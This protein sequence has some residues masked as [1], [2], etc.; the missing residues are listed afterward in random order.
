MAGALNALTAKTTT[1]TETIINFGWAD[2][3]IVLLN[4]VHMPHSLALLLAPVVA[5]IELATQTHA[6]HS[7]VMR[8]AH[9]RATTRPTDIV[10]KLRQLAELHTSGALTDDEFSAAKAQALLGR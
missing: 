6:Q 5:R 7:S 10:D 3:E 9:E 1:H 8:P 2:S 4:G